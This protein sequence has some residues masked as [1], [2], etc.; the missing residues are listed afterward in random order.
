ME[1]MKYK[2]LTRDEVIAH[3]EG[4]GTGRPPVANT[5][6]LYKPD[7]LESEEKRKQAKDL[8]LI[9]PDDIQCFSYVRPKNFGNPGD[10]CWCDVP[11]AD[12]SIH[13]TESVGIDEETAISWDVIEQISEMCPDP[14][15][16]EEMIVDPKAPDGRYRA[17]FWTRCCFERL[18][19]FRGME[20]ALCDFYLYPDKVK[21]LLNRLLQVYK[22]AVDRA[23]DEYQMDGWIMT[24]DI[25]T[26]NGPFFSEEMFVEFLKPIYKE[27]IDYIHSK[28]MHMWL[29]TCG[30]V[31]IF[32]PHLIECGLDVLHP[33][34]K[35]TM[36]EKKIL[37]KYGDKICFWA[38]MDVQ[39]TLPFGT[40]E[41][42]R[43][44]TR[45]MIDT[46]YQ[47]GKGRLILGPA[48]NVTVEDIPLENVEAFLDESRK[49]GEIVAEQGTSKAHIS[50]FGKRIENEV[51]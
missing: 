4:R 7:G 15:S 9:Y 36:N 32:I 43:E 29:H 30:N 40:Q 28:E 31:E 19:H 21:K 39:R 8:L 5:P 13:R 44:E 17:M 16:V 35:Y 25:G 23:K 51:E 6:M 49:Y 18:W 41:E 45:Y 10:Y 14:Y 47:E 20:N 34:Q 3:I 22:R 50:P 11:G 46:F 2:P 12:P 27:L 42:V 37:E 26:Q 24:D 33:I 1:Q 48:N 38:G